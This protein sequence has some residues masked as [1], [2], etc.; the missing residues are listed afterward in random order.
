[1]SIPVL[2]TNYLAAK[3]RHAEAWRLAWRAVRMAQKLGAR[4]AKL[5]QPLLQ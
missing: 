1:M 5:F 4:A 2:L 3:A